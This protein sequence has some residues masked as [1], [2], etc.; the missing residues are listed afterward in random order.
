MAAIAVTDH[1]TVAGVAEA[2]SAARKRG[3]GFLRGVELTASF[4]R[5]EVHVVGLGIS[6][7]CEPLLSALAILREE[8]SARADKIIRRL[9][10]MGVPL[11]RDDVAPD[12][13]GR[14]I[15]RMHIARALKARGI[16]R[17]V[18]E[19]FDKYFKRGRKAY[20][21]PPRIPCGQ[22]IDLI[23]EA[24]GLAILAHPGLG[25][26]VEGLLPDLLKLPFDGI[27]V[28]H[29]RHTPKQVDKFTRIAAERDLLGSGGS[30]SH[31]VAKGEKSDLGQVRVPYS[32]FERI[33]EAL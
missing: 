15:G 11:E 13:E 10:Q 21:A 8:R 12:A 19:G 6:L 23:H 5:P 16:T 29:S 25:Q 18:Q 24:R 28:Y 9:N 26:T 14:V 20:V 32:Y 17:T 7:S 27:E 1:D 30:D 3:L 2:A 4:G 31:G 33:R 22:A